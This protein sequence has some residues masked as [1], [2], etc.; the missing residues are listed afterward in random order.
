MGTITLLRLAF[1]TAALRSNSSLNDHCWSRLEFFIGQR[2]EEGI[3]RVLVDAGQGHAA[4]GMFGEVRVRRAAAFHACAVVLDDFFQRRESSV[5]HVGRS[6]LDIAQGWNRGFS[7]I[8]V[9]FRDFRSSIVF[10]KQIQSVVGKSHALEQRTAMTMKAIRSEL[11]T[12]RGSYS[13]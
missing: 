10:E 7:V 4:V 2:F 13:V 6:H 5:V 11:P 8:A 1:S 9:A 3:E 12:A